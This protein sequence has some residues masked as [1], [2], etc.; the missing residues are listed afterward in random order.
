M[1]ISFQLKWVFFTKG[2]IGDNY[3]VKR[4]L[5]AVK[6]LI[7]GQEMTLGPRRLMLYQFLSSHAIQVPNPDLM[8]SLCFLVSDKSQNQLVDNF[9]SKK[10]IRHTLT[11]YST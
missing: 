1:N 7:T 11:V 10:N 3:F 5:V 9:S 2:F 6:A 8:I 4:G